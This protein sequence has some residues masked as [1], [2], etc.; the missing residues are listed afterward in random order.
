LAELRQAIH[1]DDR[2]LQKQIQAEAQAGLRPYDIEYRVVLQ[3]GGVRYVHALGNVSRNES[4]QPTLVFGTVQ[5]ITVR[6]QAEMLKNGQKQVLEMIAACAPLSESLTALLRLIEGHTTPGMLG[7][8]LLLDKKGEHLCHGAAPDLPAEYVAAIDGLPIGPNIGSCGT[9]AWT[10]KSVFVEDIATDP[11]WQDYRAITLPH[12]LRACWST[13]IFDRQNRVIGTFAM[14]YRQP[15]LPTPEQLQLIETTTHIAAIAISRQMDQSGLQESEA[16]LK[17]AQR[18]ANLGY[19]DIDPVADRI[20]WSE[21]TWRIFGLQPQ[22]R[23]LTQA[24]LMDMIHPA[25]RSLRSQAMAEAL[26]GGRPY[27]AEYRIVRPDNEVRFVHFRDEMVCDKSGRP[28]RLFGTV[29]DTTE[30]K[31]AEALLHAQEQEIKAIVENSPDPIVRYDRELRRTYVNPA[32]IKIN[33][34][35]HAALVGRHVGSAVKDG[36]VDA[37]TE[38]VDIVHRSLKCV[39]DTGRP[40]DFE[41]TWP[42]ATGRISFAVHLEP[43]FDAQ[44]RLATI[45]S[46]ARDITGLKEH[47]RKLRQAEAELARVARVTMMGEL[48]ASIAHE[49]NQ[50]LTAVVTNANAVTRWLAATPPNLDEAREGVRRIALDGTRA[51]EVIRRIRALMKKSEPARNPLN[52][53]ELIQETVSLTRSE[54]KQKRVLLQT[55]LAPELPPVPADRVQLQQVLLNLVVNAL[56]SM[57]A[58]AD[59]PRILRIETDRSEPQA[60]H[61]SVQDTGVGIK[62]QE[63]EHLYEPFYTTK[64]DGLGMGLAISRSIVEAHGGH[65]WVTPNNGHGV[66]FQ[67]TLPVQDGGGS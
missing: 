3:D 26:Q 60:V 19:W 43:E 33:G 13:P 28:I 41:T 48:T 62:P 30:R 1:P 54:L 58:V 24:E 67:F 10:K 50:P 29:Q 64:T 27:D 20:T 16:K 25:D 31:Q 11:R 4:G 63:T 52:L 51:S 36:A 18:I 65:L 56:D 66:A 12:G 17:E 32:F 5:D 61:V 2:P 46:I 42:M 9:A 14:Y 59:R 55:D 53:N 39:F 49:V 40:L 45:L 57:S 23:T 21:E 35:P 38:E 47:E 34:G 8:I 7:S 15:G 44:G 22:N 6:K 37:T